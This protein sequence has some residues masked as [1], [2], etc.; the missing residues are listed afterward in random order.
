MSHNSDESG[1][2]K[3]MNL[4]QV[5]HEDIAER[6]KFEVKE[7]NINPLEMMITLKRLGKIIELTTDSQK[8]DKE[9]REIF[10]KA[11]QA[12]LDGGKSVDIFGAN[13]RVQATGTYYDFSEV[14][15]SVLNELYKIRSIVK[16]AIDKKEAEIKITLPAEDNKTLGIRSKKIIQEGVPIFGWSEDEFEETIF[17]PIK[18]SGESVIVTFKKQK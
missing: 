3:F 18:K 16:E 10:L 6:I 1:L 14:G 7:G 4:A 17:P 11:T 12:A 2:Q 15:D 9:V 5:P 13:L 8:G